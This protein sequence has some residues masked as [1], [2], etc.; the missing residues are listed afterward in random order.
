MQWRLIIVLAV[1]GCALMFVG[2]VEWRLGRGASSTP[3]RISLAKLIARGPEG[4]PNIILT[5]FQLSDGDYV[6]QKKNGAWEGVYVPVVPAGQP[7]PGGAPGRPGAPIKAVI[8]SLNVHSEAE[9]NTVLGKRELPALVTNRTRSLGSDEYNLLKQ[10]YGGAIDLDHCLII[11]EG[12]TPMSGAV[13]S[14]LFGG[15]LLLV[16]GAVGIFVGT[17]VI[18]YKRTGPQK[19]RRRDDDRPRKRRRRRDEDEL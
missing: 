15:G 16:L 13:I 18:D 19:K 7:Q 1:I 2:G 10:S 14:L 5:D 9:V 17:F 3:E 11:Q 4:N 6:I 12:R 8:F